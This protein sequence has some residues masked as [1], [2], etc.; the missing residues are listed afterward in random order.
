VSLPSSCHPYARSCSIS[1]LHCKRVAYNAQWLESLHLPNVHLT[2]TPITAVTP[3][4]L[5]TKDGV[6]HEFDVIV[7]ATGFDVSRTGVGLNED[8][9]GEEEGKDLK[10][11]WEEKEGAEAFLSVAVP[12]V[13]C[14]QCPTLEEY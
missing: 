11:V 3:K 1:A 4:G 14:T 5:L 10:K 12:K 13:S 9:K 8:V 7:W 2:A 6:E